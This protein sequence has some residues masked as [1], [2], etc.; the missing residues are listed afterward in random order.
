MDLE[1]WG[2]VADLAANPAAILI[3]AFFV[4]K[5]SG[6]L[7]DLKKS[8]HDNGFI[9]RHDM[10]EAW[11]TA[12][13]IHRRFDDKLQALESEMIRARNRLEWIERGGRPDDRN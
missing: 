4:W 1:Q 5:L 9:T 12:D 11:K 13:E 7:K 2:K 8:I 6:E 3:L 10:G